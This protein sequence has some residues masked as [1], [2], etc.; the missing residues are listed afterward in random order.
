MDRAALN[1]I[2]QP[3]ADS[4]LARRSRG[5]SLIYVVML[6]TI[7]IVTGLY[8][9]HLPLVLIPWLL[10]LGI[11]GMR[12]VLAL[13][14][15]KLYERDP[16]RWRFMYRLGFLLTATVWGGFA[17]M[18]IVFLG[19]TTE[20]AMLLMA[21]SGT[22]AGG[23][24]VLTPDRRLMMQYAL[25]MLTPVALTT[26][27]FLGNAGIALS[28]L[29][30]Y[31]VFFLYRLI[32][33]QSDEYWGALRS[34]HVLKEQAVELQTARAGAEE[35]TRTKAEFL[36]TM[37]HEIRTPMNG[38]IGM[39]G[40]MLD[41]DLSAEQREY[42]KVIRASGDALL[43][44]INDILDFS[45]IEAG[46]IEIET[47]SLDLQVVVEDILDLMSE[48]AAS[49][50][51]ELVLVLAPEVPR[52]VMG[53]P[54]RIR[55]IL[56]NLVGNA[57]KFTE[58]GEVVVQIDLEDED[59]ENEERLTVLLRV[60]DTGVGIAPEVQRKLFQPFAQADGSTTRKYGGTGLGLVIA[61]NLAELLGGTMGAESELGRGSEFWTS[62]P[63]GPD[64]QTGRSPATV[65]ELV[66]D[67]YFL[68]VDDNATCRGE[69]AGRLRHWGAE[70]EEA[71][72]AEAAQLLLE[73]GL[74][75]GRTPE[76]CL[77]DL[78][79]PEQDGRQLIKQLAGDPTLS[80]IPVVLMAH[81]TERASLG[82][83][84]RCGFSAFLSKPVRQGQL[85]RC[86][87]VALGLD[88]TRGGVASANDPD[89]A[90]ST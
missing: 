86:L 5:G 61:K 84:G 45:K 13:R 35:A 79:L 81:L 60:R 69:L 54:G 73:E 66:R 16:E 59:D 31:Y 36:A 89:G 26:A 83:P 71:A 70:V 19:M 63:F 18:A 22:V 20:S 41:T 55:Q 57:I 82:S 51:L 27:L 10:L 43:H 90:R 62:L 76:V 68:V 38:I 44:L 64:P 24:T 39:S 37:S 8:R 46:K 58:T 14:F 12:L 7:A 74:A 78:H 29:M 9:T 40:L 80:A 2:L 17:A 72:D 56:L 1:K 87:A 3:Q 23:C 15:A 25:L 33:A 4:D 85:E 28:I 11:G 21:T 47:V 65:P 48:Q 77:V 42:L 67:R 6:P 75:A 52:Q 34:N 32:S 49:K 50:G 30:V 88:E 53:D